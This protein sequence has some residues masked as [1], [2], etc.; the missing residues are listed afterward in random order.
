MTC[1]VDCVCFDL[2]DTLFDY[3]KYART[4]L[5]AAADLLESYTGDRYHEQLQTLYFEEGVTDGTFDRLLSNEELPADMVEE[6]V[7]AYHEA[8]APLSPYPETGRVLEALSG[9][10]LGLITDGRGG[11]QKLDRLGLR[12]QFDSIVV[13]PRI[14]TSKHDPVAFRTVLS[15]LNVDAEDAVYVGDDPRFDFRVP[16]QLG[17]WT[18]RLRRGRHASLEPADDDAAP[19]AEIESLDG[20]LAEL[21]GVDAEPARR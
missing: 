20:L 9:Y 15:E 6:L 12:E 1:R 4:G 19:D 14:D 16:N 11:F 18:I 8:T 7:E 3:H 21:D 17:M 2:D 5:D 10:Q 13:T